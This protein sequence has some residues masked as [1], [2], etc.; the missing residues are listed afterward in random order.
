[1]PNVTVF[2]NG[3]PIPMP[4]GSVVAA[5]LAAAGA[6]ARISLGGEPRGPLCGMG[7]CCECRVTIDGQPHR[8]SCQV[9]CAEG[10]QVSTDESGI[11]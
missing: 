6:P 4:A 5:A 8:L 2:V 9:V 11:L 1:M 3:K 7:I 10:M